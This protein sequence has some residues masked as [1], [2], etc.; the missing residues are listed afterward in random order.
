M[1]LETWIAADVRSLRQR[2]AGGFIGTVPADRWRERVD[3]GGIAPVYVVWHTARHH[4]LSVNRVV[5]GRDEILDRW[6]DRVGIAGDTFRGLSEGEDHQLVDQLDPEAVAEY[7]LAVLDAT[8]AWLDTADIG[9][10]LTVPDSH[11]ALR[12][13]TTPEDRFDWLYGMWNDKPVQ[14]FLGWE[15]VGHGYN[16]LGELTSIRNRMGLSPF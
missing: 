7:F 11:A 16:H 5:R 2:I 10:P 1:N 8:A 15:A 6:Q 9:D 14:F 12:A 4:D 3:G 13:I